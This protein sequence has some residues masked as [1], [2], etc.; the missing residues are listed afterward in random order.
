M[1]A[2]YPMVSPIQNSIITANNLGMHKEKRICNAEPPSVQMFPQFLPVVRYGVGSGGYWQLEHD[3][4]CT[5]QLD[6]ANKK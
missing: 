2:M 5:V 1:S 3:K 4:T 6:S